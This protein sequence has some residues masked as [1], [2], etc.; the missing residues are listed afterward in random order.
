VLSADCPPLCPGPAQCASTAAA[1]FTA[2]TLAGS[3]RGS[4][5]RALVNYLRTPAVG[6]VFKAKGLD[7]AGS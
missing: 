7:P 6:A 3:T 5:A 2:G 1:W 4:E